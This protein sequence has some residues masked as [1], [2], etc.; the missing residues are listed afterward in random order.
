MSNL[1]SHL[2][3]ILPIKPF[4]QPARGEV[5]LP[6]SKSITNRALLLAALCDGPVTLTGA[7]FSEDTEIMAEALRQLGFVVKEDESKK[8]IYVEGRGGEIPAKEAT[9]HVGLVSRYICHHW[10]TTAAASIPAGSASRH[11][12]IACPIFS[13]VKRNS[14]TAS[15]ATSVGG[16]I[17]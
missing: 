14:S 3:A 16:N 15:A 7:L 10:P 8:T 11:A 12:E 4:T 13:G 17:A 5:T 9:L 6:G 2:P 1:P